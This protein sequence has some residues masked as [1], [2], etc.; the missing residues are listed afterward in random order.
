LF[1]GWNSI[2]AALAAKLNVSL[3]RIAFSLVKIR[4]IA[5]KPDAL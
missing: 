5:L 4:F 3:L 1:V 2:T